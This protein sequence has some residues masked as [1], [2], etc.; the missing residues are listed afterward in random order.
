MNGVNEKIIYVKMKRFPS[1]VLLKYCVFK[2]NLDVNYIVK[3][4]NEIHKYSFFFN[5]A[6]TRFGTV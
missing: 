6:K 5:T 3:K 4:I 2:Q 1:R